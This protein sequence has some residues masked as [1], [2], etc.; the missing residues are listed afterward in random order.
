MPSCVS[1]TSSAGSSKSGTRPN[2]YPFSLT[3]SK[4][5]PTSVMTGS[6]RM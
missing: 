6:L 1:A 4:W 3:S 2:G 5:S